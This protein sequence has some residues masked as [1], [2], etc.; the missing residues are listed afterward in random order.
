MNACRSCSNLCP[1]C[2]TRGLDK[3]NDAP[4]IGQLCETP[5][6]TIT[7]EGKHLIPCLDQRLSHFG[8]LQPAQFRRILG[9]ARFFDCL[10]QRVELHRIAR[11]KC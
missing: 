10:G 5:S 4:L 6:V 7:D 11:I 3:A 1:V 9:S 2:D 8:K